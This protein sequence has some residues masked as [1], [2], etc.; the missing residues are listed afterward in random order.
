MTYIAKA[1]AFGVEIRNNIK[2][3]IILA[4]I[5]TAARFSSGVAE[6]MEA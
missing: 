3:T 6:I 1:D 2:A 4:N 5:V